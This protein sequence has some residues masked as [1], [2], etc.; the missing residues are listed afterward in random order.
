MAPRWQLRQAAVVTT[1]IALRQPQIRV[2]EIDHQLFC[3]PAIYNFK[4]TARII[5]NLGIFN[6]QYRF[7]KHT[8]FG[9]L[10]WEQK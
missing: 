9:G 6:F 1:S 10:E 5:I 3:L 4:I 2:A 7:S 8:F